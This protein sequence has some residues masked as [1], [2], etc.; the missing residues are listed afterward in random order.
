[1]PPATAGSLLLSACGQAET[2]DAE[3]GGKAAPTLRRAR[4][5]GPL[6]SDAAAVAEETVQGGNAATVQGA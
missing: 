2:Q 4:W 6:C 1:M 3:A 5:R